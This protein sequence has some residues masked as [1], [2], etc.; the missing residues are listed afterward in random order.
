[1]FLRHCGASARLPKEKAGYFLWL[2]R[3]LCPVLRGGWC[4]TEVVHTNRP[5]T[6]H[7]RSIRAL[8]LAC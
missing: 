1:M 7:R 4:V 3:N 5:C 6:I 2:T 8:N